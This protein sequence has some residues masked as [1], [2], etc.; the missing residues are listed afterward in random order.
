MAVLCGIPVRHFISCG[1]NT[2]VTVISSVVADT[3]HEELIKDIFVTQKVFRVRRF[4]TSS[5]VKVVFTRD[6]LPSHVKAGL[7]R[8]PVCPSYPGQLSALNAV[9]MD[10]LMAFATK[11]RY[12]RDGVALTASAATPLNLWHV[13]IAMGITM[14][15]IK[16]AHV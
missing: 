3:W 15:S 16:S 10:T 6:S 14:P 2:A 5:C 4:G 1:K 11:H 9:Q 12:A 8:Y 13:S 7:I